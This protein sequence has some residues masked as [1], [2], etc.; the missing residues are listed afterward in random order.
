MNGLGPL[1]KAVRRAG[2]ARE[3]GLSNSTKLEVTGD[4]KTLFADNEGL[5]EAT[6]VPVKEGVVVLPY[7]NDDLVAARKLIDSG[8]AAVMPLAAPIGSGL[9]IQNSA[10]LRMLHG[11]ITELRLIVDAGRLRYLAGR[12]PKRLGASASSP[13]GRVVR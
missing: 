5:A 4:Q 13:L 10:T 6:R 2:L 7:P 9:G 8:A 3:V 12:M 1:H 11:M